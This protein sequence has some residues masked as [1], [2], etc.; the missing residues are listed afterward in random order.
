MGAG[1]LSD[2]GICAAPCTKVDTALDVLIGMDIID[3]FGMENSENL[4]LFFVD[5][6]EDFDSTAGV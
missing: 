1:M 2:F 3:V 5:M 6:V 4:T